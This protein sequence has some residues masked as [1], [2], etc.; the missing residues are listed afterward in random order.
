MESIQNAL[1]KS[2]GKQLISHE[3]AIQ[4]IAD[5]FDIEDPSVMYQNV[6]E[7]NGIK[8]N[9]QNENN[10]E[11]ENNQKNENN[12]EEQKDLKKEHNF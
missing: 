6:L 3:K 4:L 9:Q 11:N 2:G 10:Q 7:E 1:G 8:Q 5:D 12:Q